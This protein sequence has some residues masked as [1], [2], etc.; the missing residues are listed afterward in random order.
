MLSWSVEITVAFV[1]SLS[2]SLSHSANVIVCRI[3][4]TVCGEGAEDTEGNWKDVVSVKG[5]AKFHGDQNPHLESAVLE[6]SI[7]L[8]IQN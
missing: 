7:Q 1:H 5:R 2:R 4:G 3:P 8:Y 6:K